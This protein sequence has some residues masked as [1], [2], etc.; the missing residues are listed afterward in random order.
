MT[1]ALGGSVPASLAHH[2]DGGAVDLLPLGGA[3]QAV[4]LH[5][6]EVGEGDPLVTAPLLPLLGHAFGCV[7]RRDYPI[8]L[9]QF[10]LIAA[11]MQFV[12]Q[13]AS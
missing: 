1:C 4:V 10:I 8:L 6:R 13:S 5:L 2:P 3:E 9:N 11:G 7:G 12:H